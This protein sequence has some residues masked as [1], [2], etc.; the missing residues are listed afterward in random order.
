M[1]LLFH[2]GAG[3]VFGKCFCKKRRKTPFILIVFS[4]GRDVALP[5]WPGEGRD[6]GSKREEPDPIPGDPRAVLGERGDP[7]EQ[8]KIP[9]LWVSRA[10]TAAQ[11]LVVL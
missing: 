2:R 6:T 1:Q 3:S 11:C 7:F 5:G 9:L 8:G 4:A 10:P